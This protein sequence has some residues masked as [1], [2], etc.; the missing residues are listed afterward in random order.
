MTATPDPKINPPPMGTTAQAA[1]PQ[2]VARRSHLFRLCAHTPAGD[3]LLRALQRYHETE[4][5]P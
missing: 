2:V 4:P 1:A 5:R 3:L